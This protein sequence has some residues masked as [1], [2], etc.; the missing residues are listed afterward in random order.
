MTFVEVNDISTRLARQIEEAAENINIIHRPKQNKK[1]NKYFWNKFKVLVWMNNG[2]N[3][4]QNP[5]DVLGPAD[6]SKLLSFKYVL[7]CNQVSYVQHIL[8]LYAQR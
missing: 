4:R 7:L 5:S 8:C 1:I 2:D 3:N 6:I